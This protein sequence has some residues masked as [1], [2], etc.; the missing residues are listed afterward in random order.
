VVVAVSGGADSLCLLHALHRLSG[1][2]HLSLHAAHL[3]HM[4][5]G[6]H[7]DGD[8]AFVREQA[9][10]LGLQCTV[11][12]RDVATFARDRGLSLEEA[13][14]EVRYSFLGEVASDSGAVV[15]LTGHT[16]DDAVETIMLHILRGAGVHGLRGLAPISPYPTA[17]EGAARGVG[18]RLVRPLLRISRAETMAYCIARG[19]EPRVDSSNESL[20]HLRNRVRL[21]LLPLMRELNPVV[22]DALLRLGTLASE[23]D[24]ALDRIAESEFDHLARLSEGTVALDVSG[25]LRCPPAVQSR[26]V[27]ETM[28]RLCGSVRDV[29]F[30]HVDAVR[31]LAVGPSGKRITLPGGT[32]WRREYGWLTAQGPGECG[33]PLC[34][35]PD[36]PVALPV[37]G[38][39]AV[40][41]GWIAARVVSPGEAM[42]SSAHVAYL[43]RGCVA[44]G[45]R[46]RRRRVGDRFRPLGMTYDK[47]LQD[48]MVDQHIAAR[49]R[50]SVPVVCSAERIVWLVGWRIDDRAKVTVAT[51]EVVRLDFVPDASA[52]RD[53]V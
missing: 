45:L 52:E 32:E 41:G 48:F 49:E 44:D 23:D 46:V 33:V 36:E 39:V 42:E 24:E 37:P 43:D 50:D 15:V 27:R 9:A 18:L 6:A 20:A 3:N 51:H 14:R 13:A 19:L 11:A 30:V 10:A 53:D 5:R 31:A 12:S 28:A 35:M 7:A 34:T 16:R 1:G 17:A 25:F 4:L 26:L 29:S 40:P 47:K 38:E 21:E 2:L 8:A 22:D